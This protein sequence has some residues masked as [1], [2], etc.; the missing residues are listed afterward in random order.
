MQLYVANGRTGGRFDPIIQLDPHQ[1]GGT[2]KQFVLQV[3]EGHRQ[4]LSASNKSLISDDTRLNT[5]DL[6]AFANRR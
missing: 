3:V 1:P 5:A 6:T 2:V 4:E